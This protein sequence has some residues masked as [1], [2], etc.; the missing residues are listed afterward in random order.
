MNTKRVLMF[1]EHPQR[2]IFLVMLAFFLGTSRNGPAVIVKGKIL[3]P[4]F[5]YV[6]TIAGIPNGV[7]AYLIC[8]SP[9]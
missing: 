8:D 1:V 9:L 3:V 5:G 4:P 2:N 7:N 6:H